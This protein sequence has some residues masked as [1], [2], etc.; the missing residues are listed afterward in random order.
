MSGTRRSRSYVALVLLVL[1]GLLA[2]AGLLWAGDTVEKIRPSI[3]TVDVRQKRPGPLVPL[4]ILPIP[5][6]TTASHPAPASTAIPLGATILLRQSAPSD[7]IIQWSGADE[8]VR[9]ETGSTAKCSMNTLGWSRVAVE[10]SYTSG[11]VAEQGFDMNVIDIDVSD[12]QIG[13]IDVPVGPLPLHENLTNGQTMAYYFAGS[14]ATVLEIGEGHYRT[15]IDR[16]LPLGVSVDPPGVAPIIEWRIDGAGKHLGAALEDYRQQEIGT[17]VV[18]VGPPGGAQSVQFDMYS[19][20][21][22]SHTNA[23]DII[24]EGVPITFEAITHPPGFEEEIRWLSSTKYGSATAVVGYGPTFRAEFNDTVGPDDAWQWLGVI[25]DNARFGQDQKP[26]PCCKERVDAFSTNAS[27]PTNIEF[28]SAD[29]PAIPADFFGPGSDPFS[30]NVPMVGVPRLDAEVDGSDCGTADTFVRRL[31]PVI[32]PGEGFPRPCDPVPIEIVGLSLTGAEKIVV[33]FNGGQ[34]PETWLLGLGLPLQEAQQGVLNAILESPTGGTYTASLPV[35]VSVGLVRESAALTPEGPGGDDIKVLTRTVEMGLPTPVPW[36]RV[37]PTDGG[38]FCPPRG[39]D[40]GNEFFPGET[41]PGPLD[42]ATAAEGVDCDTC[43]QCSG[44][45]CHG[46]P[47]H[48]H[49]ICRPVPCPTRCR[50]DRAFTFPFPFCNGPSSAPNAAKSAFV[51]NQNEPDADCCG[52][53]KIPLVGVGL[54]PCSSG[55]TELAIYINAV[56]CDP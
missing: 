37:E 5:G 22:I 11:I 19:V 31:G 33:T 10:I 30:G 48:T 6:L 47:G 8:L 29:I 50:Y 25:A 32:C 20:E 42:D 28:G 41:G 4:V 51:C 27:I 54:F 36:T 43:I 14:V 35:E 16:P 34:N 45:G 9:D 15:S 12:I 17:H 52:S 55:G 21:I 39:D 3:R 53:P 24:P 2:P 7:A 49:C 1:F 44:A 13:A 56:N 23:A 40:I 26:P 18:S 38:F 46:G